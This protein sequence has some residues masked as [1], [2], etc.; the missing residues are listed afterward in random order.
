MFKLGD[1]VYHRDETIK[2]KIIGIQETTDFLRETWY[3]ISG[4]VEEQHENAFLTIHKIHTMYPALTKTKD[5]FTFDKAK[6]SMGDYLKL[7][8][9]DYETPFKNKTII[10]SMPFICAKE[11]IIGDTISYTDNGFYT[12]IENI[13]C[14][15]EDE[16]ADNPA[17]K[18]IGDV[19]SELGLYKKYKTLLLNT[20][21]LLIKRNS[22]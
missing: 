8:S 11:V 5:F 10:G 6:W 7:A 2:R 17:I 1:I 18:I 12:Y 19:F 3:C 16:L 14:I 15:E 20:K 21:V 22:K 13:T 4:S 9:D